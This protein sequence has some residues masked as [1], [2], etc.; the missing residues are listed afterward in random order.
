MLLFLQDIGDS[1]ELRKL[2]STTDINPT[3]V[4]II[5]DRPRTLQVATKIQSQEELTVRCNDIDD[6]STVVLHLPFEKKA[7]ASANIIIHTESTG[8]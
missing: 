6:N 4:S 3:T 5:L 7:V 8:T 2:L 1:A